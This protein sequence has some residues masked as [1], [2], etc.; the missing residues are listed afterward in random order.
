[1]EPI[2]VL[3]NIRPL[4]L[5]LDRWGT[6]SAAYGAADGVAGNTPAD[7]VGRHALDFVAADHHD[8]VADI[9]LPGEMA[10]ITTPTPFPLTILGP[11]GSDVVDVIPRGWLDEAGE[12]HWVVTLVPRSSRPSP[13]DV[14]DLM[15][16]DAPLDVVV[17]ALLTH[18][19]ATSEDAAA[20]GYALL[21]PIGERFQLI[22]D[23]DDGFGDGLHVLV[24]AG[25][26]RLW[27]DLASGETIERLTEQLPAVLRTA[28]ESSGIESCHVSKLAVDG[29][30]ECVL[31]VAMRD[32]AL[33]ELR[34]N[35]TITR[36]DQLRI[37][38][39]ALRRDLAHR[40]LRS[41]ALEDSLT[42]LSN[43][44]MFDHTLGGLVGRDATLLFIDL[45]YFK[46]INDQY[47]HAVGD[48]VLVEVADRLKSACRPQ[49]IVAR[50]GGDEFAVLLLDTDEATALAVSDRLLAAIAAP[51]PAELGPVSVSASVGFAHHAAVGDPQ[52]LV[53]AADRAMLHGKRTGRARVVIAG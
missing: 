30:L 44:G 19:E 52:E 42:G 21:R 49:D 27:R 24:D 7:F 38:A 2:T 48:E 26:H 11:S 23:H 31:V 37:L 33:G 1:M 40:A 45:D 32:R 20:S 10:N 9:F 35:T 15:L 50:I 16:D 6:I 46:A 36:R 41:A 53:Q 18:L 39:H 34:G 28:G 47:G 12:L 43:R 14:I 8:D 25:N 17:R 13:L 51:L 22:S 29:E 4:V 5:V 3:A